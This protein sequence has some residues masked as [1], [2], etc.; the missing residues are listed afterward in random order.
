MKTGNN[1]AALLAVTLSGIAAVQAGRPLAIDDADSVERGQFELEMGVAYEYDSDCKHWDYPVGLTYGLGAEVEAGIGFGGQFE[2]LTERAADSG[3]E[4]CTR[5]DGIGDLIIGAK[6]RFLDESA[7]CPRQALAPSVKFP[8]ADDAKGLGS[9]ETDYDLMWVASKQLG[10]KLG[11]HINIGY[12]WI[13][14]AD[15]DVLHYGAAMDYRLTDAIQWVGEISVE[16]ELVG[17][18]DTAVQYKTGFRWNP[19]ENLTFDIV[20]GSKISGDAPNFQG[21]MGMTWTFGCNTND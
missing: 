7:W 21:T 2:E 6:W 14:G 16:K 18:S 1:I 19:W 15:E 4:M 3:E 12:S 17:G 11:A 5:E 8:T 9:G 13:G 20:G 10:A